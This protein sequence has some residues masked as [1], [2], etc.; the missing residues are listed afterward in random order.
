MCVCACVYVRVYVT[1]PTHLIRS[2][3]QVLQPHSLKAFIKFLTRKENL[4]SGGMVGVCM[5]GLMSGKNKT[6]KMNRACLTAAVA[7]AL[8]LKFHKPTIYNTYSGKSDGSCQV[9]TIKEDCVKVE[10]P[11][12]L[13]TLSNTLAAAKLTSFHC[14]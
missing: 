9:R 3:A 4:Y 11:C 2:S 1:D 13:A 5:W 14:R 10:P 7:R 12:S 6:Q 8:G